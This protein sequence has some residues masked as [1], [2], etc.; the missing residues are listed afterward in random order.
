[1]DIK[2]LAERYVA[3]WN[4]RDTESRR[5]RIAELWLADGR[6]C[7]RE[8]DSRGH[9]AIEQRVASA[10]EKW[11]RD[12]GFVF[13]PRSVSGHR[14]A[15]R[16][17]WEMLPAG[18][19]PI[20]A[21]GL[22]VLVVDGAGRI[23]EDCQFSEPPGP[24]APEV[25]GLVARYVDF[26]NETDGGTRLRRLP[27]LWTPDAVFTTETVTRHGHAGIEAEWQAA[28]DVCGVK[29]FVFRSTG[30]TEGHHDM[31]RMSWEM[32]PEGGGD[33]AATGFALLLLGEDGRI[34]ADYQI[35]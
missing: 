5:R 19:G 35:A 7:Y 26:W 32:V 1:M 16:L 20:A 6:T 10:N 17:V 28:Y 18:G 31:V 29:G 12:G 4:E 3:V 2:E 11:V 8:L 9:A 23:R 30:L 13:R 34:R 14:G 24:A 27:E 15:V 25:D 21:S 33:A 22:S